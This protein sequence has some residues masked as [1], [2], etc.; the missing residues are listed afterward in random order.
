MTEKPDPVVKDLNSW[1][2]RSAG[3]HQRRL[4]EGAASAARLIA[5]SDEEA[6][7][8]KAERLKAWRGSMTADPY[9]LHRV[10][11]AQLGKRDGVSMGDCRQPIEYAGPEPVE[12]DE[13]APLMTWPELFVIVLIVGGFSLLAYSY[14]R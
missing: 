12:Y 8:L 11:T 10:D 7:R 14:I 4:S 13:S 5:Q 1:I 9:R 3:Q 2:N 6:E